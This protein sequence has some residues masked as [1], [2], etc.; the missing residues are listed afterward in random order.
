METWAF[1]PRAEFA[2]FEIEHPFEMLE[3]GEWIRAKVIGQMKE[4]YWECYV[5]RVE[6]MVPGRNECRGSGNGRS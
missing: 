5:R 4:G 3:V 2:W 6:A 1:V